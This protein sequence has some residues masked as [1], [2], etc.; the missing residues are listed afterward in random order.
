MSL[1]P[2]K[3]I[4]IFFC[5]IAILLFLTNRIFFFNTGFLENIATKITYPCIF[6]ASKISYYFEEKLRQKDDYA[7]LATKYQ[8]LKQKWEDAIDLLVKIKAT[9]HYDQMSQDLKIFQKRYDLKNTLLTKILVKNLSGEEHFFLVNKGYKNGVKKDMVAIYKHQLVGRVSD[10]FENYSK[11]IL[12]TDQNCKI[13]AYSSNTKANGIVVGV[14]N[15]KHCQFAYVS[16]LSNIEKN[17]IVISS[18]QGLVFPE[19]F[20][21]GRIVDHSLKTKALYHEIEIAPFIKL[22]TL[23]FCLLTDNTKFDMIEPEKFIADQNY[24]SQPETDSPK[25]GP[26]ITL[27]Q[28]SFSN[29]ST[30]S[31]LDKTIVPDKFTCFNISNSINPE[32][33]L[34]PK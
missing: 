27:T 8:K 26:T 25:D 29:L 18:G 3:K 1:F 34:A 22:E 17:D 21:L 16:H 6:V 28:N 33:P 30:I 5:S 2:I 11:I 9:N 14:N 15:L 10:V 13:A 12:I 32:S 24:D 23:Q 19:G 31:S 7:K 20:C 4:T